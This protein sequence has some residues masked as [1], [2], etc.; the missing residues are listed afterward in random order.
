VTW[1]KKPSPKQ[2]PADLTDQERYDGAEWY[3]YK[4]LSVAELGAFPKLPPREPE[5]GEI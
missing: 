1:K 4:W 3:L 2:G 5:P